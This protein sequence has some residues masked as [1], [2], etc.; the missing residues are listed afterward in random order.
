M[1][2]LLDYSFVQIPHLITY[3]LS[4]KNSPPP[5]YSAV[6]NHINRRPDKIIV[7]LVD[8]FGFSLWKK[9]SHLPFIKTLHSHQAVIPISAVFP[10]TTAAALATI[11]TG[12][13]PLEHC[14]L[15]WNEYFPELDEILETIPFKILG[16]KGTDTLLEKKVNPSILLDKQTIYEQLDKEGIKSVHFINKSYAYSC[17]SDLCHRGSLVIPFINA[18]DLFYQLLV[19]IK[20]GDERLYFVYWDK[21][22]A[23]EHEYNPSNEAVRIEIETFFHLFQEEFLNKLSAKIKGE[24]LLILTADHGQI[25]VKPEE[26]IYLNSFPELENSYMKSPSGR[27]ILPTGSP[28]DVFLHI[29]NKKINSVYSFLKKELEGKA[30]ILTSGEALEKHLFGEGVV[31][32]KFLSRLGNLL[33]LPSRNN[34]VWYEH[35]KGAKFKH[36]GHHGGLSSEE[37]VVPLVTSYLSALS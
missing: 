30:Q 2:E 20:N 19:K 9:F 8:G 13:S 15:E 11:H 35:V 1:D 37:M 25:A 36:H 7:I 29:D 10:S 34:S 31:T 18:S 32:E 16:A 21:V 5:L 12:L 33:I 24:T 28:R 27:P 4:A 14:L 23:L 22:D 17:F 6:K 3:L 26:T